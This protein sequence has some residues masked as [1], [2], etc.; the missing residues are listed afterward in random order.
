M[1]LGGGTSLSKAFEIIDRFS[2]DIDITF[3]EHVGEN[4]RK[5][6]KYNILKP[7]GDTLN[8]EIRNW[9]NTR[10][11][12]N[13]NYYDYYYEAVTDDSLGGLPP[14]VKLET[15]LMTYSFPVE[16]K[17][18]SNYIYKSFSDSEPKIMKEYGLEPFLMKVQ[19]LNRTLSDKIFAICDY[20]LQNK[21]RR[22]S[23]HLYDVY[24]L[25][26]LVEINDEFKRLMN[27]VRKQRAKLSEKVTP[28]AREN[29]DIKSV[30]HKICLE[31]FYKDDYN[32]TTRIFISDN[33]RYEVVRDFLGDFIEKVI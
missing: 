9:D 28:S 27:E 1:F 18:I 14:Y 2:E 22:N 32:D 7:I 30:V 17:Y 5:K 19:S 31:D 26:S 13:Y 21:K 12:R 23:R 16:E 3:T 24:K 25:A 11:R 8:L 15:A 29:I 4:R 33:V 20:Y 10:S 6:L